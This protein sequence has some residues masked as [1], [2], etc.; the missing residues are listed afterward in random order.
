MLEPD[1]PENLDILIE[2]D[3]ISL[4][5]WEGGSQDIQ[6]RL[7][8]DAPF[9]GMVQVNLVLT[10]EHADK[11]SIST[12]ALDFTYTNSRTWQTVTITAVQ[13]EGQDNYTAELELSGEHPDIVIIG[14]PVLLGFGDSLEYI[15]GI[16]E[17]MRVRLLDLTRRNRL[18]N[19]PL[20]RSTA[21]LVRVVNT[22][23]NML[24]YTLVN[25][26]ELHFVALPPWQDDPEN[27]HALAEHA[28]NNGI[29]PAYELPNCDD[30]NPVGQIQT[31]LLEEDLVPRINRIYTRGRSF[32]DETG[33]NI[34]Q[35]AF[36]FLEWQ[37]ADR[38]LYSPLILLPVSLT[39]SN[40]VAQFSVTST[41]VNATLN[42]SLLEKLKK[43]FELVLPDFEEGGSIENYLES[44]SRIDFGKINGSVK[45][46]VCF[47]DFRA[48]QIALYEDLNPDNIKVTDAVD[49]LI[50]GTDAGDVPDRTA[51]EYEVDR[52]EIEGKVP[53]LVMDSDPS[54][55]SALVDIANEKHLAIEG[56][57]GTG[58]SQTI[59]NAIANA[60]HDGK[61]VLFVAAKKAA[62]EVVV[63]RLESH[64]LGELILPV[65]PDD[66]R[67]D[68]VHSIRQRL[69]F[70]PPDIDA[71]SFEQQK[72]ELR[73]R[74][75]YLAEYIRF[76]QTEMP[77]GNMK[78]F[79]VM[80]EYIK[81]KDQIKT[82][83]SSLREQ[84]SPDFVSAYSPDVRELISS[85]QSDSVELEEADAVWNAFL[86][87]P[88]TFE[89]DK[90]IENCRD[91]S[92][93][94]EKMI[95]MLFG[96][97]EQ[98]HKAGLNILEDI[99][100]IK[101]EWKI[102]LDVAADDAL[103]IKLD[104]IQR[105]CSVA[106]NRRKS[107]DVAIK[108]E[109][110]RLELARQY[111]DDFRIFFDGHSP[112]LRNID[113]ME[114]Q[115][116]ALLIKEM[117][118]NLTLR[119]E[120]IWQQLED[121]DSLSDLIED[122]AEAKEFERRLLRRRNLKW[123]FQTERIEQYRLK[124]S[125]PVRWFSFL[126]LN[127]LGARLFYRCYRKDKNMPFQRQT[128]NEYMSR[129]QEYLE[130]LESIK[131]RLPEDCHDMGGFRANIELLELLASIKNDSGIEKLQPYLMQNPLLSLKIPQS[132]KLLEFAGFEG[133]A[134][135]QFQEYYDRAVLNLKKQKDR[136]TSLNNLNEVLQSLV[137]PI[138]QLKASTGL[139]DIF[140]FS[141]KSI[142]EA[143]SLLEKC[144]QEEQYLHLASRRNSVREKIRKNPVLD[145]ILGS[146]VRSELPIK[147]IGMNAHLILINLLARSLS[148]THQEELMSYTSETLNNKR[149]EFS[150]LDQEIIRRNRKV[151]LAEVVKNS[152]PPEGNGA[153][154]VSTYTEM[155]LLRH[156]ANLNK[157]YRS[158]RYI[159]S[160]A[161]QALLELKPCWMM[162][163]INVAEYIDKENLYFDLVIIDEASQM[164]PHM[165][166]SAIM[167]GKQ[168]VVV[169]DQNQLPPTR[170]FLANN[171]DAGE[172]EDLQTPEES[173]LQKANLAFHPKR[174]LRW[175]YRSKDASLIAY[176][177]RTVYD[178]SLIV[179]PSPA[180]GDGSLGVSQV[181]VENATYVAGENIDEAEKMLEGIV[182]FMHKHQNGPLDQNR[183]LGI[184][185][186]ND[187]QR[188]LLQ[189]MFD[190]QCATD[191]VMAEYCGYWETENKGL[192]KFFIKNLENVQGDER[193][194]I[195]IGTVYGPPTP[196]GPVPQRFGPINGL[197]GKRRLNV[198]FSRAKYQMVTYT[199]LRPDN[200][201]TDN[202][203][204]L[205]LSGWLHYSATGK[206]PP[207]EAVGQATGKEP[208]S[209][210]EEHVISLLEDAGFTAEPQ[211]G[212]SGYFIDIGVK[213]PSCPHGYLLGVECDG[214]SYHSSKSAR[215]RDR[216]RQQVLE[217]LG[218]RFH[219]IWSTNWF[220]N[221]QREFEKLKQ[222]INDR[223]AE[224]LNAQNEN[225]E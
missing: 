161:G 133:G 212:V 156:Q 95:Q 31:L 86:G 72:Q 32:L 43:D 17:I 50:N 53:R 75:K 80:S 206:L 58:K 112:E 8:A 49:K 158:P 159:M 70:N 85:F 47:G 157:R 51:D 59:V 68:F 207:G 170:F 90:I 162:S 52:P 180:I 71:A 209:P 220:A 22:P 160:K 119:F 12:A 46:Y 219:R 191:D 136:V 166:M 9:N 216:L 217:G 142:K 164:E 224:V 114:F 16:F 1:I 167:R 78:V 66:S 195:F 113:I 44:L 188:N 155:G 45:R 41:G 69:E 21:P 123:V 84:S 165:A 174:R 129:L 137:S 33:I 194:A 204:R 182:D 202:P 193:D 91:V 110:Q 169:G 148:E 179:F 108:D 151:L 153:G 26:E 79:D 34:V 168:V 197:H 171:D 111:L 190:D 150:K 211:I 152:R 38:R 132:N 19:T 107:I 147:D 29:N 28:A 48:A 183:S 178:D 96:L 144:I 99:P 140:E 87:T 98:E 36:G 186:M 37:D 185:V 200:I 105:F 215:E 172:D 127:Y 203:G 13:T 35:G 103:H 89:A 63:N 192:E 4:Q 2:T 97:F 221:P 42:R 81:N 104:N 213:H 223:L 3:V 5:F 14:K 60:L 214:A 201:N 134:F 56:P 88:S 76:L 210:F 122:A 198:L 218:W 126:D 39:R 118:K 100:G 94:L 196:N 181:F 145:N 149:E 67:K 115:R 93:S 121:F 24:F 10:G 109:S 102:I 128:A 208:D 205:M 199:S 131:N 92:A 163:P 139:E 225:N 11:F 54:Q 6:I 176:S 189:E 135:A 124:L 25:G 117:S 82:L 106:V 73:A 138:R 62:I 65:Y 57:P 30:E 55:F 77:I 177:N 18:I 27:E 61:K 83:P 64:D 222:A 146:L 15:Q 40:G 173:I 20:S 116:A 143:Q 7:A 184:V 120:D 175:H 154:R 101:E 74:K 187:K 130:R 141:A 125:E 23:L